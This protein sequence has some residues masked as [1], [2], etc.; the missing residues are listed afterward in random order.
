M[1]IMS[2]QFLHEH[3]SQYYVQNT[4]RDASETGYNSC[5]TKGIQ[6]EKFNA[7]SPKYDL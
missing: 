1:H 5:A 7:L 2:V 3:I 6:T 4:T